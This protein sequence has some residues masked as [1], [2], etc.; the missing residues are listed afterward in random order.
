MNIIVEIVLMLIVCVQRERISSSSASV[1]ERVGCLTEGDLAQPALLMRMSRRP[2]VE[3]MCWVA[4]RMEVFDVMSSGR[5]E[6]VL[7]GERVWSWVAARW[8]E[9]VSRQAR[10]KVEVEVVGRVVRRVRRERPRPRLAPV[11]RMMGEDIVWGWEMCC[12]GG[13]HAR[14]VG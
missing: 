2:Y 6:M 14:K 4:E 10:R 9:V 11:I 8:P 12:F 3:V 1:V 13:L 5:M 7:E